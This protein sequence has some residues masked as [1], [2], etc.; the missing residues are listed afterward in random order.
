MTYSVGNS[1]VANY[2]NTSSGKVTNV[3]ADDGLG[4][5]GVVTDV[6]DRVALN[7]VV[8]TN[9]QFL[10]VDVT[11][12]AGYVAGITDVTVTVNP[13]V[14]VYGTLPTQQ[15]PDP[16]GSAEIVPITTPDASMQII[17]GAEGDTI[18]LVNNGNIVGFGGD[19][20]GVQK[21]VQCGCN[22]YILNKSAT[23]GNAA[24]SLITP[25]I[26]VTIEN[27]GYIA[28]GGGGGGKGSII[29]SGQYTLT[30]GG[31]GGAGGG[32]SG[33]VPSP[34]SGTS[35][36]RAVPP[37]AGNNGVFTDQVYF[38]C[39]GCCPLALGF[40]SGGGGGFVLPGTGG[41]A[42]SGIQVSGIGGGAGGSG[43]AVASSTTAWDNNGGGANNAAPTYTLYSSTQQ[44]GGGGGWGASGAAGYSSLTLNQVGAVG[45]NSIVTNG[46]AY[47][48]TGS[49]QLYG[50]VNTATTSVVYTFPTTVETGTTLDLASIPGYTTGTNVVLIVPASVR[51]TSNSNA[52]PGLTI[53]KSGTS[54]NPSSVRVVLNGAILGA[55]GTGGSEVSGPTAGG[56]ALL[57]STTSL[58]YIIDNTNGYLAAGGGGGG[59]SANIGNTIYPYGGGG[60]GL[61]GSSGSLSSVA[62]NAGVASGVSAGTN[63]TVVSGGTTYAS[64]GSGGTILPGVST[65]N[66]GTFT[67]ATYAGLGGQAGGSG[68]FTTTITITSPTNY[69]GAYK[70]FGGNYTTSNT[71][72]GGGGGGWGGSG[73]SG[74]RGITTVQS[75]ATSGRALKIPQVNTIYVL[76]QTNYAG[77][78]G[79]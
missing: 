8:S 45:G 27:N 63:G 53:T 31:G 44:G 23:Q 39:G 51:L 2:A 1:E 18:K 20:G 11:S 69:G 40:R 71:P 28:G 49:G 72:A 70:E 43:A 36:S 16:G 6:T 26:S 17:G 7:F 37:N 29:F 57:L 68:A 14:Y 52:T 78:V 42:I 54:N 33:V 79:I 66:T 75:G 12:L 46:N 56:V 62:Y 34:G 30:P 35:I 25:G 76:N 22:Y 10:T 21:F 64:G 47:T 32:I 38:P 19:G 61:G 9:I 77:T 48:L 15:Y 60:A 65:S 73:G 3:V 50:T 41:V 58:T 74:R 4:G 24:L 67:A 59:R 55:G 5:A 13:N